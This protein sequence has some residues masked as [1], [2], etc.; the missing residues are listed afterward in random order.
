MITDSIQVK[1]GVIV[2]RASDDVDRIRQ[3]IASRVDKDPTLLAY[4][5]VKHPDDTN[6]EVHIKLCY[7]HMWFDP[8]SHTIHNTATMQDLKAMGFKNVVPYNVWAF[9]VKVNYCGDPRIF[10]MRNTNMLHKID[11]ESKR[12]KFRIRKKFVCA[13]K[14]DRVIDYADAIDLLCYFEKPV[15]AY[16]PFRNSSVFIALVDTHS[17]TSQTIRNAALMERKSIL[18]ENCLRMD[19]YFGDMTF[20]TLATNAG[21]FCDELVRSIVANAP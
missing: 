4:S 20:F 17:D 16:A 12:S 21:S 14:F 1:A 11:F 8:V 9:P 3:D 7:K 10:L 18:Y 2:L 5:V 19:T 6:D 13:S 15:L